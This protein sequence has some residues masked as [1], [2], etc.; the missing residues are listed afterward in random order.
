MQSKL[1]KGVWNGMKMRRKVPYKRGPETK[2][3]DVR[4]TSRDSAWLVSEHDGWWE[5]GKG[6]VELGAPQTSFKWVSVFLPKDNKPTEIMSFFFG[7]CSKPN[8]WLHT[9]YFLLN[10]NCQFLVGKQIIWRFHNCWFFQRFK[11]SRIQN[12]MTLM[13]WW[14]T[15]FRVG[16]GHLFFTNYAFHFPDFMSYS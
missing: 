14:C 7:L 8:I 11:E 5:T 6:Y 3:W 1:R 9:K 12:S 16:Y 2:S 10:I 13:I 4:S 15:L